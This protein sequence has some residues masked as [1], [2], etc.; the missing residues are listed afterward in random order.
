MKI[1]R[2]RA[3]KF[4]LPFPPLALLIPLLFGVVYPS[5]ITA[6][7][8]GI[9]QKL[10]YE[11]EIRTASKIDF[12]IL[13]KNDKPSSMNDITAPMGLAQ[14]L[15]IHFRASLSIS[16]FG[17]ENDRFLISCLF[18][19]PLLHLIT[20]QQEQTIQNET[21]S[22]DLRQKVFCELD[23]NGRVMAVCFDANA[24]RMSRNL[25]RSCLAKMQCVFP[26]TS[27]S[28]SK[29]WQI[30]EENPNGRFIAQYEEIPDSKEVTPQKATSKLKNFRK[31][32]LFYQ[33]SPQ[34]QSSSS[35][36]EVIIMPEG[37]LEA[38]FDLQDGFLKMIS[39]SEEEL[40]FVGDRQVGYSQSSI[41][42]NFVGLEELSYKEIAALKTEYESRKVV[43]PP[44]PLYVPISLE[45]ARIIVEKSTLGDDLIDK[46]LEDLK[47]AEASGKKEDT[48]LYLRF[49]AFAFIH[50]EACERIRDLII[51]AVPG[52][53]SRKL[54]S[55]SLIAAGHSEAQAALVHVIRSLPDDPDFRNGL[56][57]SFTLVTEP[58]ERTICELKDFAIQPNDE[59]AA[60][61]SLIVLGS[62][63]RNLSESNS[64]EANQ[65][66]DWILSQLTKTKSEREKD[67][68]LISLGNSGSVLGLQMVKN[69]LTHPSTILRASAASALRWIQEK[70]VDELLAGILLSDLESSVRSSAV[71]ALSFRKSTPQTIE[72]QK[73]A[74]LQDKSTAVRLSILENF[75][76]M[77]TTIDDLPK[78]L[79]QV[80]ELAQDEE[81]RKA[82]LEMLKSL[83]GSK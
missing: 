80:A 81:V 75:R 15:D 23:R 74:L 7:K 13:F 9:G 14:D 11:F 22:N 41:H 73:K 51:E 34:V 48:L 79:R 53:I 10:V 32:I 57:Q 3:H 65:I 43:T 46:L 39:G 61:L 56:I 68:L 58:S 36:K 62:L 12:G 38:K 83:S 66:V 20:S 67:I 44:Q 47:Q 55:Q 77:P 33:Q 28:G 59:R 64:E 19:D 25:A 78:L 70:E 69:Y 40:Y 27:A 60:S 24:E 2:I 72:A 4:F 1:R 37:S 21:I 82:A 76:R 18:V 49:K 29:T 50:P 45:E 17:T 5:Q 31:S 30:E 63:A 8:F 54:L 35:L 6:Y 71:F 26:D 16:I 42:V 52:S